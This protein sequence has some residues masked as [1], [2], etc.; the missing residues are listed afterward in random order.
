[1]SFEMPSVANNKTEKKED[2]N[3][4]WGRVSGEALEILGRE[5]DNEALEKAKNIIND[6]EFEKIVHMEWD[7]ATIN[8]S[9]NE[10]PEKQ[11]GIWAKAL[12][13]KI[14]EKLDN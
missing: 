3:D 7:R 8:E 10:D 11:E 5:R 4:L 13:L 6:P 1:M 12:V 14:K 2:L 9:V